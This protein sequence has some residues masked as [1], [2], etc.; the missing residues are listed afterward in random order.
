[1]RH[2]PSPI[3]HRP[4]PNLNSLT[5][6]AKRTILAGMKES[7]GTLL[8]RQGP[9]GLEVLLVHPSGAYNRRAP[10]SIANGFPDSDQADLEPSR[11]PPPP[12]PTRTWR[13]PPAA[14]PRRS[15]D[16]A[17][18]GGPRWASWPP[19][20]PASAS[21]P[22]PGRPRP[23]RS[24]PPPLRRANRPASRRGQRPAGCC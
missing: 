4:S 15:R 10:W 24:R 11:R 18:P 5:S 16:P 13:P 23:T 17:P 1:H 19:P 22:P 21:T 7:A 20:R 2:R 3:A 14:R 6:A 8:Y 9:Q 12:P